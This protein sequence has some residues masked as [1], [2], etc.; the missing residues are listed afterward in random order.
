M[1][2]LSH[3]IWLQ[4]P[5][6]KCF[7]SELDADLTGSYSHLPSF[8]LP[9]LPLS[10]VSSGTRR[11]P[12]APSDNPSEIRALKTTTEIM[13]SS[14]VLHFSQ[15]SS[16]VRRLVHIPKHPIPAAWGA[17]A[18]GVQFCE[19]AKAESPSR[20]TGVALD[21]PLTPS[22]PPPATAAGGDCGTGPVLTLLP[23]AFPRLR[24]D[25]AGLWGRDVPFLSNWW[26]TSRPSGLGSPQPRR[27]EPTQRKR[28]IKQMN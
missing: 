11:A 4:G 3:A 16:F 2:Q 26:F 1:H 17:M 27:I 18:T 7:S 14:S 6:W 24:S 22:A 8:P 28:A 9:L 12:L 23:R 13:L 20:S 5:R 21:T 19:A 15:L 25:Q 10:P